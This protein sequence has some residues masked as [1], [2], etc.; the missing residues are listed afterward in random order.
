MLPL[1]LFLEHL[2]QAIVGTRLTRRH[3]G[4]PAR[5]EGNAHLSEA[6]LLHARDAELD[7]V[8]LIEADRPVH[9]A[10]SEGV[11]V[12]AAYHA[13]ARRQ[14][15]M[16]E[17]A[18]VLGIDIPVGCD[19]LPVQHA[20]VIVARNGVGV[21]EVEDEGLPLVFGSRKRID[22]VLDC[23][24]GKVP[25]RR[26]ARRTPGALKRHLDKLGGDAV[27]VDDQNSVDDDLATG[28]RIEHGARERIAPLELIGARIDNAQGAILANRCLDGVARAR[29]A[30]GMCARGCDARAHD[31]PEHACSG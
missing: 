19:E 12:L 25:T 7:D 26:T 20:Y 31:E 13:L 15:K 27:L 21:G 30:L 3:G 28:W 16:H 23:V 18:H 4:R 6:P 17:G 2:W 10:M 1:P 5:G 9:V 24:D 11:D 22:R 8:V 14:R 29:M